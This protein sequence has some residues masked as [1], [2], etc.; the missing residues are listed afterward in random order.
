MEHAP[1]CREPNVRY[2]INEKCFAARF[3]RRCGE[4]EPTTRLPTVQVKLSQRKFQLRSCRVKNSSSRCALVCIKAF[5][6]FSI[7]FPIELSSL[8]R[9]NS[10]EQFQFPSHTH[11]N[12][13]PH[14]SS[15]FSLSLIEEATRIL[16]S[17]PVF[18]FPPRKNYKFPTRF[19]CSVS[20]FFFILLA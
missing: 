8:T 9:E 13:T 18:A 1:V 7:A 19:L 10:V 4:A 16:Q 20:L 15:T 14:V 2:E 17:S 12:R 11:T 6:V 3:Q 5:Y